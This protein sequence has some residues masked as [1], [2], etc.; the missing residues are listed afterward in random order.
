[1]PWGKLIVWVLALIIFLRWSKL[2]ENFNT[3]N[4]FTAETLISVFIKLILVL[5]IAFMISVSIGA[6]KQTNEFYE[7]DKVL[8]QSMIASGG[9]NDKI[10]AVWQ[11]RYEFFAS[12]NTSHLPKYRPF[13]IA[14]IEKI[15]TMVEQK[16]FPKAWKNMEL[17]TPKN[18]L[19]IHTFEAK[20][21]Q[22]RHEYTSDVLYDEP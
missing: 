15:G 5:A 9:K 18:E 10:H 22:R 21:R 19:H 16:V 13:D 20:L 17:Y 4:L 2:I 3:N 7:K 11:H 6:T 12:Q 1:M 8:V 14:D